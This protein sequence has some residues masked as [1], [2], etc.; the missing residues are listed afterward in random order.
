VKDS[1][2]RNTG[3]GNPIFGSAVFVQGVDA[4]HKAYAS[5]DNCRFERSGTGAASADAGL[6]AFEF[7]EVL[8]RHSL[9]AGNFRG[10]QASATSTQPENPGRLTV[11]DCAASHNFVGIF[12]SRG[13]VV[14]VSNSVITH[15]VLF[16]IEAQSPAQITSSGNNIV[17]DNAGGETFSGLVIA[18]K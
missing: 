16:G 2:V 1:I 13:G 15:N 10:F 18:P 7:S 8:V 4:T 9:A 3:L 5:L 14:R 12:A 6:S 11:D 17:V